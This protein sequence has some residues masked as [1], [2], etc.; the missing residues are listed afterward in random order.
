MKHEPESPTDMYQSAKIELCLKLSSQ[1]NQVNGSYQEAIER[2]LRW[3]P[4][5]VMAEDS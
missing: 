2:W 5:K 1:Q 3:T 4:Q